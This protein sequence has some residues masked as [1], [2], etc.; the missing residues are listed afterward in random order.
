MS[1]PTHPATVHFPITTTFLTGALDAVYFLSK[2][3]PTAGAV[4]STFKT[5]DIAINPS[6]FPLLSY[7]TTLLTLLFSAPAVATGMYE[8]IPLVKRDG[9]KSKKAQVGALHAVI[10]DVTVL[11]AA[12][13]WWTRRSNPGM[14]PSDTNILVSSVIALPATMFAAYL[15]GSLVYVY[16]MGFRGGQAKAKKAQ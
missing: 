12:F 16:G 15:G 5:L 14:V 1:H 13:N 10:N 4:A 3:A 11:G 9:L 8:F 2:Y 6:I 7:Y